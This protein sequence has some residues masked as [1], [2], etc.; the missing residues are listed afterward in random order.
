M[1]GAQPHLSADL[2]TP[3]LRKA[4]TPPGHEDADTAIIA[5]VITLV[6]LTLLAVLVVIGIYLYRNQGSYRTYEQPE[7]DTAPRD[8]APPKDKEEYFI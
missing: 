5:V 3:Y 2:T 1:E 6:F 4:P 7:P 8:E